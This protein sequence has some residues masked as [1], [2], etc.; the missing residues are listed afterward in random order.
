MSDELKPAM[1][2]EKAG[3]S[4]SSSLKKPRNLTHPCKS[5]GAPITGLKKRCPS[6]AKEHTQTQRKEK[7]QAT[8]HIYDSAVVVTKADAK[9][10]LIDRGI[11]H[12]HVVDVCYDLAVAGA[13]Q[14]NLPVNRFLFANGLRAMLASYKTQAPQ[15]LQPIADEE[16]LGELLSRPELYAL[17]DFG[18]W[19][20]IDKTFDEWLADRLKFKMSAFE[21]SKILGK[22]DFGKKHEEWTEFAPRWSPLGLRPNYTQKQA[23]AWLDAQSD[24][25]RFLL[26]A[27]RNSMKSTWARILCLTLTITYPD[28]RI[29]I[30]SETNKLSKKGMKEFRGYLEMAPNNP[31]LFQQYFGEFTVAPDEGSSLVYENPLAHLGLPQSSVESSSMESANTGSR[32]DFALFDDPISRDNGTGNEEQRAAAISKHGSIMKLR[33]PAGFALNI[34]TPWEVDDL[35][36]VMIKR[37]EEDPEHPLAVRI[38]PV[39][40]I[41]PQAKHKH[42]LDLVEDDVILNFLPKLNWRFVRD[43]MRSPEGINFFKTQYLCLWVNEDDQIKVNFDHEA[44]WSCV[45]P[46]SF[47]G[48]P[49]IHQTFISLDRSWSTSKYADFSCANVCRNQHVQNKTAMVVLDTFMERA[50]ESEL[51][52]GLIKLIQRWRPTLIIGQQDKGYLDFGDSLRKALMLRGLPVPHLRFVP[53]NNALKAKAGRVKSLELPLSDGRLWFA[54]GN[55][56]LEEGLNQMEKFD[57]ITLSNSHRKDDFPDSVGLAWEHL[58]PKHEDE[59]KVEDSEE[60]RRA[61]EDE[62]RK[63]ALMQHHERMFGGGYHPEVLTRTEWERRQRGEPQFPAEPQPQQ[64]QPSFQKPFPRGAGFAV[65]PSAMRRK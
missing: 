4:I 37:N 27:S 14:N 1:K 3:V 12:P 39:I 28:A 54:S 10:L 30:I 49:L 33:E 59:K 65:L 44:L 62:E 24:K 29:L 2:P 7:R 26:V 57:G 48:T 22:E 5:C 58:G 43:E 6:C 32:F 38:D 46:A 25:K 18:F 64:P 17:Y 40:E 63:A 45:R 19:H 23:L 13:Q 8:G 11:K 9:R 61:A 41:K 15:T 42:L 36:D 47:F 16:V 50:R 56:K 60:K 20:Q 52:L 55:I 21:L 35:G 53:V 31:T 51:I 34:Q